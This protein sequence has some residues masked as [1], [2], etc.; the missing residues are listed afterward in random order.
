MQQRSTRQL[1]NDRK[2]FKAYQGRGQIQLTSQGAAQADIYVNGQKLNITQPFE[3]DKHYQYSLKRRTRDG[4]NTLRV[5]NILPQ[6]S[7]LKVTIPSLS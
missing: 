4:M 1:V 6:G 3:A 2:R 5:D 7:E